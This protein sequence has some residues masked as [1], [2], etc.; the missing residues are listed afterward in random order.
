[1][2]WCSTEELYFSH[3][4]TQES[5]RMDAYWFKAEQLIHCIAA[6]KFTA[7]PAP[8]SILLFRHLDLFTAEIVKLA[9]ISEHFWHWF[10]SYI[11]IAPGSQASGLT[12]AVCRTLEKGLFESV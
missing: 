8:Q 12:Q 5:C 9:S 4:D 11:A 6:S 1:M 3:E 2:H 7:F 10:L